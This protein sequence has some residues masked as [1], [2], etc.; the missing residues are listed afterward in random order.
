MLNRVLVSIIRASRW[1]GEIV[2]NDETFPE[3]A[4]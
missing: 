2:V 4:R 3:V 1:F